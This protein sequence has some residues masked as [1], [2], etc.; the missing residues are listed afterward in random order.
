MIEGIEL[1]KKA[2]DRLIGRLTMDFRRYLCPRIDWDN[3]LI[4]LKGAKGTGKTTLIQQHVT[5]FSEL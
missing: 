1:L 2:S 5:M 4:C 3:R